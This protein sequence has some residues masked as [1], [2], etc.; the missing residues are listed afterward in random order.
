MEERGDIAQKCYDSI[1][2]ADIDI[3]KNLYGCILL[4]GGTTVFSGFPKRLEK[5]VKELA[6]VNMKK[7]VKVI[8]LPDRK[9]NAWIGG[10]IISDAF[11]WI[12]R[13][14]YNELGTGIVNDAVNSRFYK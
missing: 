5:D 2:K 7:K 8:A 10:A 12:T 13:D 1:N 11:K 9:Y 6:P 14:D 4:S 3:H